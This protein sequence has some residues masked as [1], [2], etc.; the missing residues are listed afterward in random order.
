MSSHVCQT[1]EGQCPVGPAHGPRTPAGDAPGC[2]PRPPALRPAIFSPLPATSADAPPTAGDGFHV[3]DLECGSRDAARGL[4][5]SLKG[6][7]KSRRM[8]TGPS[9]WTPG[10]G[11][12][13]CS[14]IPE[15]LGDTRTNRPRHRSVPKGKMGFHL[16]TQIR[17]R[18]IGGYAA[19]L[20]R[21]GR[22]VGL[23][24]PRV[25]IF[26]RRR[27][28][29]AGRLLGQSSGL[30]RASAQLQAFPGRSRGGSFR[31]NSKIVQYGL[32]QRGMA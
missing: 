16:E 3:Y 10:G 28:S 2:P 29:R 21:K 4:A 8:A 9:A 19:R 30:G 12:G 1:R 32:E 6:R 22:P 11:R 23:A 14:S 31:M 24:E 20:L 5:A 15:F 26:C 25:G 27:W 13:G 18:R 17:T 7:R